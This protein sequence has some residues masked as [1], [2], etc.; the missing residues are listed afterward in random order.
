MISVEE[1]G[2]MI[3][4]KAIR[5]GSKATESIIISDRDLDQYDNRLWDISYL[6]ETR[7]PHSVVK[8]YSKEGEHS[9][10][11]IFETGDLDKLYLSKTGHFILKESLNTEQKE[12]M[13]MKEEAE[14]LFN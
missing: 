10:F 1:G 13:K 11:P 8:V 3:R 4:L 2:S 9:Y 6:T 14:N 12:W 5:K 7:R